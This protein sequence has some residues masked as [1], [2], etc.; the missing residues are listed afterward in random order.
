MVLNK[1]L[2][3]LLAVVGFLALF[4]AAC[5]GV[6]SGTAP[7]ADSLLPQL[8]GY[9]TFDA[10]DIQGYIASLGEIGTAL[11]GQFGATAA[12]EAVDRVAACYQD[13]GA[14]AARG[15][16]KTDLQIVAGVVA[17]INRDLLTDPQTF[18]RCVGLAQQPTALGEGQGG[19][20]MVPCAYAYST[21]IS[22]DT[23][24]ILYA[25]TDQ[26]ACQAFCRA[27]PACTGHP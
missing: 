15:Y 22:G 3:R 5:E 9:S 17:V 8:S 1:N 4:G 16:S 7:R 23:F 24:D 2:W 20:G 19:G 12:I 21:E 26:E 27:L 11:T 14:V 13:V 18:L 25:A 10:R 6:P